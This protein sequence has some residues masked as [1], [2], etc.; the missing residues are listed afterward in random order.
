MGHRP[1]GPGIARRQRPLAVL[2]ILTSL[3]AGCGKAEEPLVPVLPRVVLT[4]TTAGTTWS[5]TASDNG[6]D[7]CLELT[8]PTR[9]L[10]DTGACAFPTDQHPAIGSAYERAELPHGGTIVYGPAPADAVTIVATA[11]E[12]DPVTI[13]T[14]PVEGFTR[15]TRVFAQGLP[16]L[17]PGLSWSLT[18]RT[19]DGTPIRDWPW[20][21]HSPG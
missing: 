20:P 8:D 14:L 10:L 1:D 13:G 12:R 3:I 2:A 7:F 11:P 9:T 16:A 5:L 6:Q 4:G 21:G 18:A 17:P 15:A 19:A